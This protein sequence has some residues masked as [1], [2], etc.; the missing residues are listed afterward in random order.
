MKSK[1]KA[2]QSSEDVGL[3]KA[4]RKRPTTSFFIAGLGASAGGLEALRSFFDAMPGDSGVAFVIVQHLAPEHRSQMAELLARHTPMPV[5]Q[6]KDGTVVEPNHVY[7]IPPGKC[8]KIFHGKLLLSEFKP[9]DGPNLPV[10]LFFRSLAEDCGERAIGITLSGAG[11]D[12]ARGIRAIKEAGGMVMVQDERSA[13]FKGMPG[14]VIAT[15]L[16]DYILPASNMSRE[17]LEF[18]RNP[19]IARPEEETRLPADGTTM[20]KI[21]ELIRAQTGIDFSGYKQSTVMRRLARRMG[22]TQIRDIKAYLAHLQA[23]PEEVA[24]LGRDLLISVTKFFRD[25]ECFD[26]LRN[27]ILPALFESSPNRAVRIWVPGCATGEEAYSIAMLVHELMAKTEQ[28]F[29]VKIFAT[30]VNQEAVVFAGAGLYPMSIAADV[31]HDLLA[32]YFVA[33]GDAWRIC[34]RIREQVVF[35]R[36]NILRD[37]PFTRMDLVSCR[38]LLIYLRPEWQRKVVSQLHFALEPGGYL[39]LG[40]SETVGDRP[41]AF[42]PVDTKT[43]IYRKRASDHQAQEIISAPPT[44]P[45][46]AQRSSA[47]APPVGS[48]FREGE[49]PEKISERITARLIAQFVPTCLVL[50]EKREVV[51]SFGEPQR[52]IAFQP[53]RASFDIVRLAPRELSLAL[54][55]AIQKVEREKLPVA[56]RRV[57]FERDGVS[58]LV[59][60]RVEPLPAK[61]GEPMML[62]VFFEEPKAAKGS[63]AKAGSSAFDATRKS[64]QRIAD[65]EEELRG[66]QANLQ[67]A[68]EDKN[69]ANEEQQASNEEL[70]ASNE[71]LQSGNEEL[72]SVNEELVTLNTELQQ[73][74]SELTVA[75]ND[76]ENFLR[77]SEVATIF[78]D[79]QLRIRRFT[80]AV[81]REIPLVAHDI[82]RKLTNFSHPI[83]KALEEDLALVKNAGKPTM[84][85]IETRPDVWHL[86]R[87][88]PYRRE[89]AT[90]QGLVVT[91]LD[92]SALRKGGDSLPKS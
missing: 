19:L 31:P 55:S 29:D 1:R 75:N 33:E 15:G 56:Y 35:A 22:I 83:I 16:A 57:R 68:I 24:T 66:T 37:P 54:S 62:L 9:G 64:I 72:E 59:N 69:A 76:L 17:L 32:R 92:V 71:E 10:D 46:A 44:V 50:N 6:V 5:A 47:A 3:S 21:A 42:E 80:P 86:L 89:G 27:R 36:H 73:K 82:G 78:L 77:T 40:L 63:R 91:I 13:K 41:A 52:F 81:G 18:I 90:D 45:G 8:L 4:K 49:R 67:T 11:S 61:E 23:S 26:V 70:L 88:I 20:E 2:N 38:N 74:I 60:L 25:A 7:L 85:T 28:R 39:V 43:R 12:G 48:P 51:H 14:S 58:L 84:K 53:G 79:E 65:L 87:V 30:D 34:R